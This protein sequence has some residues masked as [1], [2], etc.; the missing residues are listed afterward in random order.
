MRI[1]S[2]AGGDL[3]GAG[4][5]GWMKLEGVQPI[6]FLTQIVILEN[7]DLVLTARVKV[8]AVREKKVRIRNHYSG[9]CS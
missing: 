5:G 6:V 3:K 1:Q 4:K 7:R 8:L 9:F 2:K